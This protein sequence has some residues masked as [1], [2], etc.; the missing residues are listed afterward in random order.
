MRK[1]EKNNQS[2]DDSNSSFLSRI[3]KKPRWRML[4]TQVYLGNCYLETELNFKEFAFEGELKVL[5]LL[6]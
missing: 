6:K 4:I 5:E 1:L 2:K 3:H